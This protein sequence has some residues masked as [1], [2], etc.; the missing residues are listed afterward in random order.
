M[1]LRNTHLILAAALA[2]A[3]CAA[4]AQSYRCVGKDGKKYYGQSIPPQCVG[5]VVEQISRQG[6]VLKRIDP[7]A[8][9]ADERA[10]KEAE[11]A[12]RRKQANLA[13]EQARRD[14]ALL[15]TYASEKDL[16]DGRRRALENDQRLMKELEGKIA[17]LR[18][19]RGSAGN[20]PKEID[21][22]LAMQERLLATKKS[23]VAAI[24]A[25]YDEDRKRYVELTG[26]GK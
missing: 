8:S 22:E 5:V 20:D 14:Q 24:N 25:K 18:Q 10:K 7:L 6:T 23:E 4:Q 19:R 11:E 15:A 13:R 16:E 21:T 9:S 3:S 1:A 17:A 26:R 2:A 12:E